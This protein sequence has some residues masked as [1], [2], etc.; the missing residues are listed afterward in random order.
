MDVHFS[1]QE[2]DSIRMMCRGR[3]SAHVLEEIAFL[4]SKL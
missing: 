3:R 2:G 1:Q 4:L